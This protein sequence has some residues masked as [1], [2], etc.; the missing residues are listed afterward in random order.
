[1]PA[2]TKT[3]SRGDT[4][5]LHSES[6]GLEPDTEWTV[7][8]VTENRGGIKRVLIESPEHARKHVDLGHGVM[9]CGWNGEQFA[10]TLPEIE[11]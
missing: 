11:Q 9:V 3:L 8:Q 2:P 7:V 4:L 5:R 1:M 10:A 6:D